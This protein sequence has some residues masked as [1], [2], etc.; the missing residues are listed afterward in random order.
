MIVIVFVVVAVVVFIVIKHESYQIYAPFQNNFAPYAC[1][2]SLIETV[3]GP[4]GGP[5]D[6]CHAILLMFLSFCCKQCLAGGHHSLILR[7]PCI[8]CH[9]H[10]V[11][12]DVF[13][14]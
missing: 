8:V 9:F 4:R 6:C 11:I 7:V 12:D 5:A 13:R 10:V 1:S 3:F 2:M 14:S